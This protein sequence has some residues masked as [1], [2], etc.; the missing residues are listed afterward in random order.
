MQKDEVS[1]IYALATACMMQKNLPRARNVLKRLNRAPWNAEVRPLPLAT[2]CSCAA[3]VTNAVRALRMYEYVDKDEDKDEDEYTL[4]VLV[5]SG[6]QEAEYL[7]RCWLL[8]ADIYVASNKPD[9]ATD[10][11][12]R[13]ISHNKAQLSSQLLICVP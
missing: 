7:E 12:K 8:L 1:A 10:L 3:L 5:C 13:T 9:L 6:A 4:H 11:L 2:C